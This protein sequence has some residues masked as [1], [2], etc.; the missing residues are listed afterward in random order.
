M[1]KPT[2][3][4]DLAWTTTGLDKKISASLKRAI[5]DALERELKGGVPLLPTVFA[6]GEISRKIKGK[7]LPLT[8]SKRGRSARKA[9][10]RRRSK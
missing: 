9:A 7:T 5:I 10:A 4:I 8:P 3:R 1:P 6:K 2:G